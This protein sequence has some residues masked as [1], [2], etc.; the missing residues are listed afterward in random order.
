MA[1]TNSIWGIPIDTDIE[2]AWMGSA[3][4]KAGDSGPA[5]LILRKALEKCGYERGLDK[6]DVFGP[7]TTTIVRDFQDLYSL[8][9]TGQV[10]N[11]ELETL[12]KILNGAVVPQNPARATLAA[13]PEV[14]AAFARKHIP[15]TKDWILRTIN[16]LTTAYQE[17]WMGNDVPFSAAMA[18]L[19]HFR[20]VTTSLSE[21]VALDF[22]FNQR[23]I[24]W[25]FLDGTKEVNRYR[26]VERI[27]AIKANYQKMLTDLNTNA[28]NN[29]VDY[30]PPAVGKDPQAGNLAWA[31]FQE[32]KIYFHR[33]LF[34]A[35]TAANSAGKDVKSASWTV[36]HELGH[37][38][39]GTASS[40]LYTAKT[41][42]TDKAIATEN[43][44]SYNSQYYS[45]SADQCL[46]NPDAYAHFAYQ[47]RFGKPNI[48]PY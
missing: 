6:Y 31:V 16:S 19:Y 47:I 37:L 4:L 28:G 21:T 26:M 27:R 7:Y 41:S 45:D 48:G 5:V 25:K 10:G 14:G 40:H 30:V 24:D 35:K 36:I 11:R 13:N 22:G 15:E 34:C 12:D 9:V 46:T 38:V 44:Y 42:A 18:L 33:S 43:A 32:K 29:F 3:P 17:Y 20:L 23:R 2:L 39:I 8:P 1:L